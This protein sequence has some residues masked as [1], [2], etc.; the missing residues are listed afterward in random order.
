MD[1]AAP[2]PVSLGRIRYNAYTWLIQAF[3]VW[4]MYRQEYL[5]VL[6]DLPVRDSPGI[7][8]P[9]GNVSL[10][11][12]GALGGRNR[13]EIG[14]GGILGGSKTAFLLVYSKAESR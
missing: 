7:S 5:G 8:A 1:E 3:A 11:C 10:P 9:V 4:H 2:A 12:P 14:I 6:T 13:V